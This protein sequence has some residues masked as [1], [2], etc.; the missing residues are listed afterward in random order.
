MLSAAAIT[1]GRVTSSADQKRRKSQP[2]QQ[3]RHAAYVVRD[4]PHPTQPRTYGGWGRRRAHARPSQNVRPGAAIRNMPSP[5]VP[6]APSTQHALPHGAAVRKMN[7]LRGEDPL[8][9]RG[10]A[11]GADVSHKWPPVGA[12]SSA[13][14]SR[15][16]STQ[17]ALPHGSG[18]THDADHRYNP[19][20]SHPDGSRPIRMHSFSSGE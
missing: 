1:V 7:E 14:N 5:T 15:S 16:G 18:G 11:C 8:A 4:N 20:S 10:P 13:E 3:R 17:H 19:T 12:R 2:F 9:P 6:T